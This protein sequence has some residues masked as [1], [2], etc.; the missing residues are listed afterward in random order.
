MYSTPQLP[1]PMAFQPC[2]PEPVRAEGREQE[3]AE[4]GEEEEGREGVKEGARKE[5]KEGE[6]KLL[7]LKYEV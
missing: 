1:I 4:G 3:E 5:G 7:K 2:L 6:R